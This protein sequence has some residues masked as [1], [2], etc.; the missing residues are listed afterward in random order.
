MIVVRIIKI[1]MIV[2]A[3]I[4]AIWLCKS[5]YNRKKCKDKDKSYLFY[6]VTE[7]ILITGVIV[8]QMNI[9]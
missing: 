9:F 1:C 2:Y 3:V 5:I 6:A 4:N 8:L 7:I